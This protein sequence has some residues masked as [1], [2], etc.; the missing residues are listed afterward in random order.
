M[1]MFINPFLLVRTLTFVVYTK[2]VINDNIRL[3]ILTLRLGNNPSRSVN[4][5]EHE[6]P[7]P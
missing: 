1:R 6:N 7:K 5:K 3:V 2:I 4:E